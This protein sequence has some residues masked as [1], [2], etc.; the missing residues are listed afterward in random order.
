VVY[1][2]SVNKL[3]RGKGSA[4]KKMILFLVLI[5]I[6]ITSVI[7]FINF[8]EKNLLFFIRLAFTNLFITLAIIW[9]GISADFKSMHMTIR[10]VLFAFVI[11]MT[12]AGILTLF[13]MQPLFQINP[14]TVKG[15]T[16]LL[17]EA[18]IEIGVCFILFALGNVLSSNR[19]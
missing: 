18:A 17:V 4:M 8:K 9:F 2:S 5:S 6:V 19:Q 16:I 12:A 10:L 15:I 1:S 7:F 11:L 13:M 3:F 14:V